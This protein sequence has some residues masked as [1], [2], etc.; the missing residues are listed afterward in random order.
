M[1]ADILEAAAARVAPPLTT[2]TEPYWRSGADGRLRVAQ[3]Q[4]CGWR[5]HPPRPLCPKCRKDDIRFEPVSGRG[6]VFSYTI[7]RYAWSPAMAPPYVIAEVELIEQSGLL[8]LTNIVG[9]APEDVRIGMPVTVEF[10]QVGDA[11]LPVF[12][13]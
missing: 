13:P 7:N 3:C 4:A 1:A 12:R 5:P 8:I 2:R 9:C 6:A 11:F 10:E